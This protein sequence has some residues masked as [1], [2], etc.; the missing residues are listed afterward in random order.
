MSQRGDIRNFFRPPQPTSLATRQSASAS[1][2]P[3]ASHDPV[4]A[5]SVIPIITSRKLVIDNSDEDSDDSDASIVDLSELLRP[6]GEV[7]TVSQSSN[8]RQSTPPRS[9]RSKIYKSPHQLP[10]YKFDLKSLANQAKK[11]EAT[12]ESARR[13]EA[14]LGPKQ[15]H[16]GTKSRIGAGGNAASTE[17]IESILD[18]REEGDAQKVMQAVMRTEATTL[19]QHWYFFDTGEAVDSNTKPQSFPKRTLPRTGWQRDL[20]DPQTRQQ[21]MVSGFGKDMVLLGEALPDELVLWILDEMCMISDSLLRSS[22]F[23]L[24][25]A[26]PENQLSRLLQPQL[27]A[28]LFSKLGGSAEAINVERVLTTRGEVGDSYHIRPWNSLHSVLRLLGRI[29]D[30]LSLLTAKYSICLV[31][32]L[33]CD[34]VVM[35]NINLLAAVQ[36]SLV[37]LVSSIPEALWEQAV[38][39]LTLR[40]N[41]F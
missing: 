38:S 35:S 17:V 9:R 3:A 28:R 11:A 13:L 30:K 32:R 19:E 15:E 7:T 40:N 31:T 1:P 24:I 5:D 14:L 8:T 34:G 10:K 36:S 22:Y 18:G 33:C 2:E 20:V 4:T 6:R 25:E 26:L 39:S 12:E 41:P 29:A 27:I 23:D 21:I 37:S 16:D